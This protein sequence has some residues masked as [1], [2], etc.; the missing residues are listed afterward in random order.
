MLIIPI[1]IYVPF[2]IHIITI[3]Y[4][5]DQYFIIAL[6]INFKLYKNKNIIFSFTYSI[7]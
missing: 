1:T 7:I 2:S 4:Y 6:E 5:V 3:Y